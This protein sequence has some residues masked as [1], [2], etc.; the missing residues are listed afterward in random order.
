MCRLAYAELDLLL[1]TCPWDSAQQKQQMETILEHRL[2][3]KEEKPSDEEIK[4]LREIRDDRKRLLEKASE[5]V[6]PVLQRI[7]KLKKEVSKCDLVI[8]V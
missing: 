8:P 5:P 3:A 4:R 1:S 2:P 6:R 7:F